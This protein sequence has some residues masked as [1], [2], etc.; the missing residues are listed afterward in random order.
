MLLFLSVYIILPVTGYFGI[1]P[2][3]SQ[4]SADMSF[5]LVYFE[6]VLH[7]FVQLRILLLQP[8]A[9][10]FMYGSIKRERR[11]ID[12]FRMLLCYYA[13]TLD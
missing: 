6:Y 9:Y 13:A 7:F 5:L 1:F 3:G 2:L 11:K 10:I 12:F 8:F 4:T